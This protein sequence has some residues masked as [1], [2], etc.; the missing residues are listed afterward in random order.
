MLL[1][2]ELFQTQSDQN[3]HQ[4]APNCTIFSNSP[5]T[6]RNKPTYIASQAVDFYSLSNDHII[7]SYIII[8]FYL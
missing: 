1:F 8:M 3:I 5:A 2:R 7:F 4:N 6:Y